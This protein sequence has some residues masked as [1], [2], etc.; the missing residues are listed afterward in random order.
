VASIR[1]RDGVH[2]TGLC[3]SG[4]GAV[5]GVT[6]S[7]TAG[8]EVIDADL[9]VDASGVNAVA[10]RW[11]PGLSSETVTFDRWYASTPFSRR[12]GDGF[13]MVFPTPPHSRSG[14]V[15]PSGAAHWHVS[16]SGCHDDPPPANG[17]EVL[18]YLA[19][20][21]HPSLAHLLSGC[22]AV[23]PT[24]LFRRPVATRRLYSDLGASVPGLVAVGDALTSLN[25]LLGLGVSVAAWQAAELG[26]CAAA[27]GPGAL[28]DVTM[29]FRAIAGDISDQAWSLSLLGDHPLVLAVV[30]ATGVSPAT[31]RSAVVALIAED[32]AVHRLDSEVWHLL[33][34]HTAV[35][36]PALVARACS[37]LESPSSVSSRPAEA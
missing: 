29:P 30:A 37:I 12:S 36:T 4:D 23:G 6:C 16:V 19:T 13:W 27:A 26:A 7:G 21:D 35:A 18:D 2:V 28:R 5:S 1:L 31:A 17:G 11:L 22:E 34:P 25:P 8:D 33:A 14:L 20:L 24:Q 3:R 10:T 15:S 9:V 32:P